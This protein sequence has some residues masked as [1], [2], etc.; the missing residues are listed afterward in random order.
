MLFL[1]LD[2]KLKILNDTEHPSGMIMRYVNDR[3]SA[4]RIV[5]TENSGNERLTISGGGGKDE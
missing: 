4:H 1:S 2:N 3:R 5:Q